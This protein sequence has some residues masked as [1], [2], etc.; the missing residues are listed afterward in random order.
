M[1]RAYICGLAIVAALILAPPAQADGRRVERCT[2][3]YDWTRPVQRDDLVRCIGRVFKAP[4][5]G[6]KTLQVG[7]CESGSDLLDNYGGDGYIGTFQHVTSAWRDR[8][9]RLGKRTGVPEDPTNVL[10]QA[11]VSVKMAKH[12]GSWAV[13]WSC[14]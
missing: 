5:R 8:W 9:E 2:A 7:L 14:A 4:G 3:R 10:S 1:A 13:S 11:V 12:S 6:T